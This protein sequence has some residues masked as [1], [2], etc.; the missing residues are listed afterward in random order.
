M[1]V[2]YLYTPLRH[3]ALRLAASH[4]KLWTN[5]TVDTH[6]AYIREQLST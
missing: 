3:C 4:T 5:T 6:R 1:A 2:R